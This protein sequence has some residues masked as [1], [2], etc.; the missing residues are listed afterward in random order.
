[1]NSQEIAPAPPEIE[2]SNDL[3]FIDDAI[4]LEGNV[5]KDTGRSLYSNK[6]EWLHR[7][8]NGGYFVVA[9]EGESVKGFAICDITNEGDFKVWL[10]GVDPNTR[11]KGVWSIMYGEVTAYAKEKGYKYILLNT[12]PKKFP[13]M[14]SFLQKMN[15]EIYKEEQVDGFNK[16]YAKIKI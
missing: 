1:L 11:G 12:F 7:I 4:E 13:M 6:D 9:K 8:S 3:H 16:V 5:F 14:F 10:A 2:I 15:A